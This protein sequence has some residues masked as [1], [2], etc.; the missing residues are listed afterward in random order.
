MRCVFRIRWQGLLAL[1]VVNDLF[2]EVVESVELSK[3]MLVDQYF[4]I[5]HLTRYFVC[6]SHPWA[7]SETNLLINRILFIFMRLCNCSIPILQNL[8]AFKPIILV[9]LLAIL[10]YILITIK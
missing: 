6:D 2:V 4:V 8:L 1:A 10:I 3:V 9:I 7:F 5:H